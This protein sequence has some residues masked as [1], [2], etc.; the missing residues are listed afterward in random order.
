MFERLGAILA[1]AVAAFCFVTVP[2]AAR[3]IAC[4]DGYQITSAG[5]FSSP[6]CQDELLAEVARSYGMKTSG[7]AIRENVNYKREVC[8]FVGRD[9]RAQQ[10]CAGF[11]SNG[12]RGY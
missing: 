7:H 12:R 4:D 6:Y 9:T 11:P 5:T 8:R 10:A 2:A 1:M 3:G